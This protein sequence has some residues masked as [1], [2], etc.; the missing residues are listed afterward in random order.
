MKTGRMKDQ[1]FVSYSS[2]N[3]ALKALEETNSF[4]FNEKPMVVVSSFLCIGTY[5][6]YIQ[7]WYVLLCVSNP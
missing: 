6:F 4:K 1:A 2:E 7:Y 3:E 5:Y